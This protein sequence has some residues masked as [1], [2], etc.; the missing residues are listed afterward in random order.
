MNILYLTNSDAEKINELP[1]FM[2]TFGDK[3][4]IKTE[5]F[6]LNFVKDKKI[7]FIVC[8]RAQFLIKKDIIDLLPKK[9]INLHPSFLPWGR[10]Y[11]PNYWSI[12]LKFPHGV[13]IHFIDEGID[14]VDIIAQTKCGYSKTETLRTTYSRLRKLMIALFKCCWPEIRLNKMTGIPQNAK[15]GNIF[16]K[17]ESQ[18]ILEKLPKKWDTIINDI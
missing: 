7:D 14:S 12:K 1:S 17:K 11:Y 5:R 18:E 13:T 15:N 9:I 16:Y 10:G 6:D 3:V 8:D 4:F 2:E